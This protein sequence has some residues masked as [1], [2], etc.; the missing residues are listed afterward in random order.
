MTE[1]ATKFDEFLGVLEPYTVITA[2]WTGGT[3][4]LRYVKLPKAIVGEESDNWLCLE[5]SLRWDLKGMLAELQ[6]ITS[7]EIEDITEEHL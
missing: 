5:E 6:V 4:Q 2:R 7:P 3:A 1:S